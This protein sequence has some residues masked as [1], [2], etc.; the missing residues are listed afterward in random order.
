MRMYMNPVSP[1]PPFEEQN[2]SD[3][4]IGIQ[5]SEQQNLQENITTKIL[6]WNT[7]GGREHPKCVMWW[8]IKK[9]LPKLK[10]NFW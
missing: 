2:F 10:G 3:L 6:Q 5:N 7:G 9:L 4:Y 1:P 8:N